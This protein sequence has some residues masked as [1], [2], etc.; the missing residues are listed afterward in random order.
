MSRATLTGLKGHTRLRLRDRS[1]LAANVT[2]KNVSAGRSIGGDD[3]ARFVE[4]GSGNFT[5]K[6]RMPYEGWPHISFYPAEGGQSF[7]GAYFGTG[8]SVLKEWWEDRSRNSEVAELKGVETQLSES[9]PTHGMKQAAAKPDTMRTKFVPGPDNPLE[10]RSYDISNAP[11]TMLRLEW[12][13]EMLKRDPSDPKPY[14]AYNWTYDWTRLEV[15]APK[16]GQEFVKPMVVKAQSSTGALPTDASNPKTSLSSRSDKF[17]SLEEQK[18]ADLIWRRLR[19][20]LEP[21]SETDAQRVEA[22]GYAGGVMV[23]YGRGELRTN[24]EYGEIMFGDILVGLHVWPTPSLQEVATVLGRD[25]LGEFSPLKFYIVRANSESNTK[26]DA[27][28]DVVLTGRISIPVDRGQQERR[29]PANP[30]SAATA[31]QPPTAASAPTSPLEPQPAA[32]GRYENPLIAVQRSTGLPVPTIPNA[33]APQATVAPST[34]PL[35]LDQFEPR[36]SV[37]VEPVQRRCPRIQ[38][39]RLATRPNPHR[40]HD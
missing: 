34:T 10:T 18:L 16:E 3:Q 23:K 27:A 22:L 31:T 21:L 7:G 19:L 9:R 24:G 32:N 36:A 38:H 12:M 4:R 13:V 40:P 2:A 33:V 17:P 39:R 6:V 28:K 20:E 1:S 15:I 35:P 29:S 11:N 8:D 14:F 37:A 30:F 25:D 26:K 5:L